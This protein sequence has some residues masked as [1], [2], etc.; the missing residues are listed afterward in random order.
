MLGGIPSG[1]VEIVLEA[2]GV[3]ER[4]GS[5]THTPLIGPSTCTDVLTLVSVD[6]QGG[7]LRFE[8]ELDEKDSGSPGVCATGV[9]ETVLEA[10]DGDGRA[11][12]FRALHPDASHEG[13]VRL[14]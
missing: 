14:R 1:R 10:V 6:G 4:V 11:A 13:V 8:A 2:G 9:F 7:E 5:M 12:D 3:G